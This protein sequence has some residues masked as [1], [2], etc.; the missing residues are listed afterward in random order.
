MDLHCTLQYLKFAHELCSL[1]R[2]QLDWNSFK[3]DRLAVAGNNQSTLYKTGLRYF[4]KNALPSNYER[5]L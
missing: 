1:R 4:R 5:T 3:R 2:D